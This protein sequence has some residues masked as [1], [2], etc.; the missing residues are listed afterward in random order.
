[1]LELPNNNIDNR[2][3]RIE[4]FLKFFDIWDIRDRSSGVLSAGQITRVMLVKA[5]IS[6][7]EMVLLDEPTASL[8]VLTARLVSR[9]YFMQ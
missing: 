7:P 5:F 8:D 3:F 1:M 2:L 4:K 9:F 6:H